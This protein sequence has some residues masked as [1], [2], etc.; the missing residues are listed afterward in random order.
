[1]C[2]VMKV[3]G[4]GGGKVMVTFCARPRAKLEWFR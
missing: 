3:S 4:E 1:M 2:G